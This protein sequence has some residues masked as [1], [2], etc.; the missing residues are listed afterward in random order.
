MNTGS[1]GALE[2]VDW[3]PFCAPCAFRY[4]KHTPFTCLL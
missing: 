4:W 1:L 2:P 3:E